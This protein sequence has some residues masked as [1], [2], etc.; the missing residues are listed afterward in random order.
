MRMDE[1]ASSKQI[2]I[3][4]A[5][6]GECRLRLV[7]QLCSFLVA[8]SC[9]LM[10]FGTL[11]AAEPGQASPPSATDKAGVDFARDIRPIFEKRCYEC[12]GPQKQKSGLRLDHKS[13]ALK[14]GD[15]GKPVF[16][17][18][19]SGESLLLQKVTSQE[20]EEMMPPKGDR[21]TAEQIASLKTW[22]EQ[23][24]AWPDDP[25]EKKHWAYEKPVRPAL[26]PVQQQD[27]PR[28]SIDYFVLARLEKEGL[29]PSVEADLAVLLRRASLDL[30][31]LPPALDEVEALLAD[32]SSDAY[33]KAVDRLLASAHYGE[34]WARPWL[35]LARYADTQGYEKDN[36][37]TVWPYR[38][39]V[40]EALNG[41]MPF[42]EFTIEQIAGDMLPHATQAQKVATG[43]HRN[44]MTNTEGGTDDEEFRYE[45]M[46]DR[47]NTT[48][49]VWM[50]TTFGCA[51]CHNHKY[52][53]LAT[54]EYYQFFAF[55]N[56]T[57][58]SDK[59]DEA[60]TMKVFKPGQE[61]QLA[62]LREETKD[63]EKK[64]T[65]AT[66]TPE[67]ARAQ[68][69]WE[70]QMISALTNW[71]VLDPTEFSS[72]GGATLTKTASKSILA[73]G[74]NP[75][76]D[77]YRVSA[78]VGPGKITGFRL[79][80]LE[81]GAGKSLGRHENGGFVLRGF[82]VKAKTREDVFEPQPVAIKSASADF[83]EKD[84]DIGDVLTGKGNGWAVATYEAKNKVRRSAY[85]RLAE[86]LEFSQDENLT[87]IL[88]HSDKYPGANIE[89]FRLYATDGEQA[90]PPAA[91]PEDIRKIL[92]VAVDKRE[93]KQRAR[94]KEFFQSVSL[95][96]KPL[97][98]ALAAGRKSE[99]E[100]FESIPIT[101]VM[102]ELE[103][104]RETHRHLRGAYLSKA[105]LV[106]PGTPAMLH[107]FPTNQPLNR[108]GL[109][110]WLVDTNNPLTARVIVNRF[111]EQYFGRGIVETV[112]EFGKQGEPPS[113]PDLLDWLAC[114]FVN[115]VEPLN[116]SSVEPVAASTL[117]PTNAPTLQ[118]FNDSTLQP[119]N[120]STSHPWSLKH[121]HRLIVTSAA[122]RQSSQVTPELYQRDPYN[123][124]FARG[125]RVRL[126][127][128]MVRDQALAVSGLL[129][130]KL[131]GPSVMP[132]QP[133]GLWQVVYS[134]DKWVTSPGEDKY[135]RGLYTFWRRTSPHPMMTAFDAPSREYCVLKR[136][137]SNT[138]LQAL[139][140][141]NDPAFVEAAQ[142][143]ARRVAAK[144]DM[145]LKQ[146]AAYAFRVCLA[147]A[148]Q[149]QE[150]DR[151]VTLYETELANY[152]VDGKAAEKMAN[153]ELGK[154]PEE[155]DVAELAAWTVVAN[156]LL[157]L[158]EMITKG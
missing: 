98:E 116:R 71:Q 81:T 43:F 73:S 28:T 102:A 39:W 113:H 44:T 139:N 150:L 36:R 30:I 53:P 35:D 132:P 79:E 84:F 7:E 129:S 9:W 87:F 99:K 145:D 25:A 90:G 76:N 62:K 18:G 106:S 127:A 110:R 140:T 156:V 155:L 114:E 50:G 68:I 38:D 2:E 123:R 29:K 151:L 22:I 78:V 105:E 100:F 125:P 72:V 21:L 46:V 144:A 136:S 55:L 141:L 59:D 16:V 138:P 70:Q 128:E 57:A 85:F 134:G 115:P 75:S 94:L 54:K 60:P 10:S 33:E 118:R 153:S 23:G 131:G 77:T 42:D 5:M 108:L 58:D 137:R 124:L 148:P 119:F 64:L 103:K 158:D 4:R 157:N 20:P 93:D 149:P 56:N 121:I 37:R 11:P 143:L 95:E 17:A 126:E 83:S 154:A 65:E 82:E 122:Y 117:Q 24:A 86:P 80:V 133:E 12:H 45:A 130:H 92:L 89:R 142:A 96:T 67:F 49:S 34:R 111:W 6:P 47:I 14:G 13:T 27:W 19:K 97:Q 107:S 26:P 63:A 66:G 69:E 120:P 152:R 32:Q 112:E 15:S 1:Q 135:R 3:L 41:D 74:K 147:R 88:R 104:P 40:I 61:E 101:S 146:R 8:A 51:Q 109:A 91:L 48:M 31:G 52:D